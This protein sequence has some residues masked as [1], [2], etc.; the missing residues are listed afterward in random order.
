[1]RF[2]VATLLIAVATGAA[3]Q[4]AP[5]PEEC[6]VA[7]KEAPAVVAT[8]GDKSYRLKNEACRDQFITD[9]ERYSQL[10]DALLELAAEGTPLTAP[11][12]PSLVPS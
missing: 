11:S 9:P 5:E 4:N 12:S 3:A 10:Y 1:M 8:Y 2:F 7:S 6:L